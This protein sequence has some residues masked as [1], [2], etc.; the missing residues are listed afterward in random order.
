MEYRLTYLEFEERRI[1][2]EL[3]AQR[4]QHEK[5]EV[6]WRGE[7]V[8]TNQPLVEFWSHAKCVPADAVYRAPK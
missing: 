7:W 8:A 4:E 5:E 2:P 3:R 1:T 6:E